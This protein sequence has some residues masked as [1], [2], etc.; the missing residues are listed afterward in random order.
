MQ[1]RGGNGK[2]VEDKATPKSATKQSHDHAEKSSPSS[3][4]TEPEKQDEFS[5]AL[6]TLPKM[7]PSYGNTPTGGESAPQAVAS[8]G[9]GSE[10]GREACDKKQKER[11]AAITSEEG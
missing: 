9:D 4:S 6:Q 7:K 11:E 5:A 10:R 3:S 8:P 1:R 2:K